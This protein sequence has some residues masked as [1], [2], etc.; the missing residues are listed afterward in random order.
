MAILLSMLQALV[1]ISIG[2]FTLSHRQVIILRAVIFCPCQISMA[3]NN[4]LE[5]NYSS[6]VVWRAWSTLPM[7]ASKGSEGLSQ[8]VLIALCVVI[9]ED[10]CVQ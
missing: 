4:L 3:A 1:T 7:N 9:R 10:I 6:P 2:L 8:Q 5:G